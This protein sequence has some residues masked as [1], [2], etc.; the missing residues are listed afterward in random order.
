MKS[1]NI[2]Q[3]KIGLYFRIHHNLNTMVSFP[4][5]TVEFFELC[6]IVILCYVT[7]LHKNVLN[8]LRWFLEKGPRPMQTEFTVL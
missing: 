3:D 1:L 5:A 8:F 6:L 7:L 2:S 4:K